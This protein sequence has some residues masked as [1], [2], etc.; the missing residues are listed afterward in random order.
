MSHHPMG[1]F[2]MTSLSVPTGRETKRALMRDEEAQWRRYVFPHGLGDRGDSTYW[3]RLGVSAKRGAL[4]G[5]R[6]RTPEFNLDTA[7]WAYS[8]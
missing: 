6:P 2:P 4:G 5:L 8:P 7:E 3:N 1:A